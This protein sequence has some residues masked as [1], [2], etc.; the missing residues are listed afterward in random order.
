MKETQKSAAIDVLGLGNALVDVLARAEEAFLIENGLA[1]GAMTLIEA[2]DARALY[3]KIG[4][5]VEV[6]GG[7]AAN[8]IAGV[9]GFGGAAAYIGK[10]ADD[11]LG[12]IFS[13]DIKALGVQFEGAR[14]A[15]ADTGRCIIVVT[16]DAQRTMSTFLGASSSL[17]VNDV[18]EALTR[19]ARIVYLEG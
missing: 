13:H 15:G 4:P 19:S 3:Q 12:D 17:S 10:V 11:T 16:P 2:D 8:T 1:K 9:A 7:S 5:A 6:S 14:L 18:D